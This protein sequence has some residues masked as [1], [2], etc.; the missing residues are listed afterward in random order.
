MIIATVTGGAVQLTGNPVIINCT[1]GT[2]PTYFTEYMILLKT[3]SQDGKLNGAP[4]TDA[5]T[6]DADGKA[7]FDISGILDQPLEI[8]FD[9]SLVY[10]FIEHP[11]QAFNIQVQPGERYL[12][13]SGLLVEKWFA[14]S[15]IF[16]MVKGGLTPRQNALMKGLN[17]TYYSKYIEGKR[18]LTPRPW[19]DFV[20]PNQAV[21]L[22]FMSYVSHVT[23][24]TIQA[25]YSDGTDDTVQSEIPLNIDA[26]YELNCNP[27]L[28]GLPLE[29]TGK[30]LLYFD[31]WLEHYGMVFSD[32][33]RFEVDW[34]YCERPYFL[35]FANSLG[36]I[37]DVYLRGFGI[38]SFD[39]TS[40]LAY[41]PVR[42]SDTVYTPTIIAPNKSG[43]NKWKVNSGWKS[44]GTILFFRDLMLSK[45]A[46]FLNAGLSNT[47]GSI[48]PII[49]TNSDVQLVNRQDDQWNVD[50]EF[51]EAHTSRFAIDNRSF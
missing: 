24:F 7:V 10:K 32:K 39:I 6:P 46:W 48:V 34:N 16:Q 17:Q 42:P 35:F 36:G 22:W 2:H 15:D 19:G 40:S 51:V 3:I 44:I 20:H 26:L 33:R 28:H 1:G 11:T 47:G 9:N 14:V 49:I 41:R 4:F 13:S 8:T 27:A 29:P 50:I 43:Q 18:F 37:D 21:K 25:F 45:Q 31:V 30:R 23:Y 12:D 5:I 38:D